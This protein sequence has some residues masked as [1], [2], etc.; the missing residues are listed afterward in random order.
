[1]KIRLSMKQF[2][3]I[4]LFVVITTQ[5]NHS[6]TSFSSDVQ[7]DSIF[8]NSKKINFVEWNNLRLQEG[9]DVQIYFSAVKKDNHFPFFRIF[10]DGNLIETRWESNKFEMKGLAAGLHI[11][12]VIPVTTEGAVGD[13]IVVSIKVEKKIIPP[14]AEIEQNGENIFSFENILIYSL[15]F[16]ALAQFVVIIFLIRKKKLGSAE[17]KQID[18]SL[19]EFSELKH[20][21]KRLLDDLKNQ[22]EENEYLKLKIRELDQNVN[23]LEGVNVN[24]LQQKEKLSESKRKLEILHTQKEELFAIAVHDIKNP[25]SAI[26]SYIQLLNSYELNAN[27]QQEIMTSLMSS[28]ENII[29]LSHEMCEII[30]KSMPEPK[31]QLVEG[32]VPRIVNDVCNQNSSYAKTKQ[33]KLFNKGSNDLPTL[34]MDADK[35]QEALDNLVNNAIKYA[36]PETVVEVRSYTKQ[37]D[38]KS[39]VIEVKDNGVGLSEEDIKKCFVKG[40]KLSTAPTGLEKSSGLGLWIVKKIIEEHNGEV[41]VESKLKAGSTFG[42]SLPVE[43]V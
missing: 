24:L 36:P 25:A 29:K 19:Q 42:F 33:V 32:S 14:P 40:M 13:P 16:F 6:Q 3:L 41:W 11:F 31:M 9:A 43:S 22:K 7:I 5:I 21:H 17:A 26:H 34:K 28:S 1:M 2:F 30:A 39:V 23:L 8:G 20:T 10:I 15:V 38:K 35:I 12:R 27:E 4:F 18:L 37:N